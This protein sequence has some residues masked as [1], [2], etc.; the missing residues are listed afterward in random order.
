M[1]VEAACDVLRVLV[2][3][4]D[5]CNVQVHCPCSIW[6]NEEDKKK[7][8]DSLTWIDEHTKDFHLQVVM[9]IEQNTENLW[10]SLFQ[11]RLDSWL[12]S[13]K[14]LYNADLG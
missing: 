3:S 2:D 9:N 14:P 7:I 6:H 4:V 5:G 11:L 8:E 1:S 13:R 10:E 12:R